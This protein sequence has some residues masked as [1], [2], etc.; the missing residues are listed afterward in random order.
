MREKIIEQ[1]LVD[2]VEKLGGIAYKFKSPGRKN[3]PDRL[4]I[5]YNNIHAFVECKA[6]DEEPTPA[7]YREID[8][9]KDRGHRALWVDRK[10][11]VVL[12]ISAIR[13]IIKGGE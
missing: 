2:E 4:C 5:F 12:F 1:Y 9:L 13:Q 7:Q 3:V 10:S 8:R 11:D 6:T